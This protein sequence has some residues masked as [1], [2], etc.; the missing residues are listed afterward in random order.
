MDEPLYLAPMHLRVLDHHQKIKDKGIL[1][2]LQGKS[3]A[4][5]HP[6]N[7][8]LGRHFL[9]QKTHHLLDS[10]CQLPKKITCHKYISSL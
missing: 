2:S 6:W 9:G 5:H 4:V 8:L 1:E 3:F 10:A 7:Y